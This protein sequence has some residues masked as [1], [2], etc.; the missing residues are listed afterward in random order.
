MSP[1]RL[2]VAAVTAVIASLTLAGCGRPTTEGAS[3]GDGWPGNKPIE[4]VVAFAPGGAV[5]TAARL[6]APELEKELGTNVEVVNRP[7]AGGQIGYTEL[8]S[9]KPDGYT[10][11]ATG[12]PSVVVSPLDPARGAKFTRDSFQPLGMQVVDPAVV[13]VAPDS[14]YTS[15]AALIDAAKAQPGKITA[16]TTG[17]QTGEHFAI[18]Q[19][20]QATGA[21]LAPVHFS[22]GQSQAVAAFLGNHVPVY[23]GS[24]SDV[25]DLVKQNKIRVLG[26]MDSQRSAFLPE[27]PTFQESGFDV[28]SA[29]ARGYS[30]PAGVPEA[31]S[32]K[33]QTALKAAIENETVKRRMTDLGLET[34]YLDSQK[35][36]DLWTEQ[37]TTY[38]NL[39]PAVTKEGA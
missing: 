1:R 12:S 19:I 17:I 14:P 16:T 30:A 2:R 27:V 21:E 20:K 15:L 9:A 37:E 32:G 18:A 28:V 23:V 10:I 31:V 22:E 5:D 6:V 24:A 26:V 29:T 3:S 7:G 35:Y 34:R 13:G 25:I 39:M 38:K 8:T 36:E 11:G 33:L 4:L